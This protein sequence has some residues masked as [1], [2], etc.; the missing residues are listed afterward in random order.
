MKLIRNVLQHNL[1][2]TFKLLSFYTIINF[3]S[4]YF[5]KMFF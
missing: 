5:K 4:L 2:K 1:H 3:F